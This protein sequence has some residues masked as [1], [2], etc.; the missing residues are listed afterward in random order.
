MIKRGEITA[1]ELV[2][3]RIR[4]YPPPPLRHLEKSALQ[5]RINN[6]DSTA[7]TIIEIDAAD[8]FGLLHKIA[9]CFIENDINIVTAKLSTRADQAV[10]VFYICDATKQKITDPSRLDKLKADLMSA[11]AG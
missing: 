5:I 7:L 2:A 1:D 11:L 3:E 8:N 10:D 9:R 6:A 4:K